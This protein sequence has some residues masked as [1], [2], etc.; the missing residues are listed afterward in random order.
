MPC[1]SVTAAQLLSYLTLL[2]PLTRSSL[3]EGCLGARSRCETLH[4]ASA[5]LWWG[6]CENQTWGKYLGKYL[7]FSHGLWTRLTPARP[8]QRELSLLLYLHNLLATESQELIDYLTWGYRC[9]PTN[10]QR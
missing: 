9:Y 4:P 6:G 8:E 5:F 2:A 7:K 10:H 3:G 1:V